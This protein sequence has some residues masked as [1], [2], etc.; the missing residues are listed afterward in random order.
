VH[1]GRSRVRWRHLPRNGFKPR[2]S[3]RTGNSTESG[4]QVCS[5][6]GFYSHC[7]CSPYVREMFIATSAF[8]FFVVILFTYLLAYKMHR[9]N[10]LVATG[11][12]TVKRHWCRGKKRKEEN[13][14]RH[15]GL[16]CIKSGSVN[17]SYQKIVFRDV[18][19]HSGIREKHSRGARLGK[20]FW[21]F[22]FKVA[23]IGVLSIF[24]ATTGPP[25]RRGARE[26]LFWF[27]FD[28]PDCIDDHV[29]LFVTHWTA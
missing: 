7:A 16:I 2:T 17:P 22:L 23:H 8:Q 4:R 11:H 9:S 24:W 27:A 25:K 10:A 26:K 13:Y 18:E 5:R 14:F 19:N 3:Q 15:L 12:E 1:D 28:G 29:R 20:H 6:R 21:I